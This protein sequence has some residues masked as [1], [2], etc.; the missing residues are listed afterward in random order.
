MAANDLYL[1]TFKGGDGISST[2]NTFTY[3]AS[4]VSSS[5]TAPELASAFRGGLVTAMRNILCTAWRCVSMTTQNLF[6]DSDFEQYLYAAGVTGART[7]DPMPTFTTLNFVSAKPT[8]SQDPARKLMGWFS[9]TDSAGQVV[10]NTGA[11]LTALGAFSTALGA[12]ISG[13]S[14]SVFAPVIT[15]RIPY[16]TPKGKKAYR[17]PTNN[18]E[19]V[20]FP[21]TGWSYDIYWDHRTTRKYGRG[22]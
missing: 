17:L 11:M 15:K 5:A 1:I 18:G 21:A 13:G 14:G 4:G 3:R 20:T 10:V 19:T 2:I 9:E 12:N 7:G 22:I 16:T 6:A 8:L